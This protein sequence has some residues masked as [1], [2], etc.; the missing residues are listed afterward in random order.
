MFFRAIGPLFVTMLSIAIVAWG[1]LAS[2]VST[3]GKLKSGVDLS[4]HVCASTAYVGARSELATV[5][6]WM[7]V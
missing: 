2:E 1:G 5:N 6:Q 7:I 3:V 4:V